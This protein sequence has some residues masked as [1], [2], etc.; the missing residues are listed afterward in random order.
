LAVD[1]QP[2]PQAGTP[3]ALQALSYERM[4]ADAG[5]ALL[6]S[7][8]L[9]ATLQTAAR[10]AVPAM[11][12]WCAVELFAP[13]GDASPAMVAHGDAAAG[14]S[15]RAR[16]VVPLDVH[17]RTIGTM[18]LAFDEQ[19]EALDH[20]NR[21]LATQLAGRVTYAIE[22]ARRYGE[23]AQMVSTLRASLAPAALPDLDGWRL[24]ASYR[25]AAAEAGVGGDFYAVSHTAAGFA[26][27]LGDVTGHGVDA[28]PPTARARHALMAAARLTSSP[29]A[30]VALLN[31]IIVD[32]QA[33][34]ELLT[35]TCAHVEEMPLGA[36]VRLTCAGHP[37]P[38]LVRR[39]H[40]PIAVGAHEPLIGALGDYV[41]HETEI[42]LVPGDTLLFYSDGVTDAVH[43]RD[44][45]GEQRLR[46]A[47]R[48]APSDPD[49]LVA[50]ID[51]VVGEWQQAGRAD[52]RTMVALQLIR[53]YEAAA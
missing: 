40:E 43:R 2:L 27:A 26:L 41:W 28:A 16:I 10:V 30:A 39:G 24:A 48:D 7:L 44:R 9:E 19:R 11:A 46:A 8:D 33:G 4:L 5:E 51:R 31:D 49:R 37:L 21:A 47:V 3:P 36:R 13:T 35:V 6:S 42:E 14:G 45:F 34:T 20:A 52:D 23:R 18:T 38:L 22:N 17:G 50:N 15:G 25:P 32:D 12:D 1:V 53:A 29:A